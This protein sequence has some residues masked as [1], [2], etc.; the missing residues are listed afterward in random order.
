MESRYTNKAAN[1]IAIFDI[2][3]TL[4]KTIDPWMLLHNHL[5]TAVEGAKYYK[6]WVNNEISYTQMTE[7]DASL[8]K[9]M[10]KDE[11]LKVFDVNPIRNGAKNLI[12]WFKSKNMP[13]VGISTG[14]SFLNDIT[15]KELGLD[16]VV[17]NEILFDNGICTGEVNIHVQEDSKDQVL[18]Q[19]LK[20]YHIDLGHIISFGDGPADI[21]MFNLSTLS[22]AVFPRSKEVSNSAQFTI[23]TEPIDS[24]IKHLPELSL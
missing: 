13:C 2:D 7:L 10:A 24:I 18:K 23:Q 11:M 3:G 20:K 1:S 9:G 5:G 4:R 22:V 17:S 16:E 21:S 8:W 14:L 12:N 15:A 19:I 6:A